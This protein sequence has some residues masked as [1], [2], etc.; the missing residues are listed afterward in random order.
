[1]FS[2][3]AKLSLPLT[4]GEKVALA[5]LLFIIDIDQIKSVL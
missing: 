4:V 1:M 5:L 2:D 3:S